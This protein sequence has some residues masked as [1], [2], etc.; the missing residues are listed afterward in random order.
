MSTYARIEGGTVVELFQTTGDITKMFSSDLVWVQCTDPSVAVGW[1]YSAGTFAP[2][3]AETLAAAQAAQI[4]AMA[5]AYGLAIA[6]PVNFTTAAGVTKSFQADPQSVSNLQSM[7]AAC[8]PAGKT[9]TGFYWVSADNTQVPFALADMQ[10]LA[11]AIG[12]QG[13]AAFQQLQ[14]RKATINA[15]TSVTAVQ[16]VTW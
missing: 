11:S 9:P 6:Q 8:T 4:A 10:G 12:A 3:T 5:T 13:W 7:L 2:L 15:A 1:R 16:A 14:A